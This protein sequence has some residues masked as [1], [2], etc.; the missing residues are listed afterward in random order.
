MYPFML[1]S[2]ALKLFDVMD[3]TIFFMIILYDI[4]KENSMSVNNSLII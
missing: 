3:R 2:L 4:C 1:S